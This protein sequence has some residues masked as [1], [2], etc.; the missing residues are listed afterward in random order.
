[1]FQQRPVLFGMFKTIPVNQIGLDRSFKEPLHKLKHF[2]FD[3][4]LK[5]ALFSSEYVIIFLK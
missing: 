3:L 5:D 1:M 4:Y 2:T